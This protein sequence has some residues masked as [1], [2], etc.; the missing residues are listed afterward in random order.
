VDLTAKATKKSK[1]R[2][3]AS[4]ATFHLSQARIAAKMILPKKRW[5]LKQKVGQLIIT[6]N[7]LIA[8]KKIKLHRS[9][10]R[11]YTEAIIT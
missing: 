1:V 6:F 10:N 5:Q 7:T 2:K 11:I 9:A 4:F 3:S 8:M